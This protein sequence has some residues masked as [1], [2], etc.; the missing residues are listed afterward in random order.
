MTPIP[1]VTIRSGVALWRDDLS[2]VV[3][4]AILFARDYPRRT[5]DFRDVLRATSYRWT[6]SRRIVAIPL[7]VPRGP[8]PV[9]LLGL[10]PEQLPRAAALA[11]RLLA[12]R[13]TAGQ[14]PRGGVA[15]H[16]LVA[17][18]TAGRAAVVTRRWV[19]PAG[20]TP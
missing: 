6:P 2:S 9:R 11:F 5:S 19:M 10:E 14:G 18:W 7:T 8:R 13:R 3:E 15:D 4:G 17:W 12:E 16:D 1:S 20:I